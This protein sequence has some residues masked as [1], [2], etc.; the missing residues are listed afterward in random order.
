MSPAP[1]GATQQP[2]RFVSDGSV[3]IWRGVLTSESGIYRLEWSW[4][5]KMCPY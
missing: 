3:P 4:D 2:Q 1:D 5:L